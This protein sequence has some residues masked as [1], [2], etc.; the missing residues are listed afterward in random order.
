M[1]YKF[2]IQ[3][4]NNLI[5]LSDTHFLFDKSIQTYEESFIVFSNLRFKEIHFYEFLTKIIWKSSWF[6]QIL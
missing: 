1:L 3:M 6:L 5:W 4:F 2:E